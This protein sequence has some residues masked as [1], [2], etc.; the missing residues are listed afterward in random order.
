MS[1]IALITADIAT[2]EQHALLHSVGELQG[3]IPNLLRIVANSPAALRAF[4]D[5][6]SL[7]R[8]GSLDLPTRERIAIALAQ[9]NGSTYCLSVHAQLGSQA[10]L[11]GAEMESNRLGDSHDAK[12]AVAVR[13]AC[14]LIEHRGDLDDDELRAMRNAG[15]SDAEIVE[16]ISHTGLNFLSNLMSK[17][18]QVDIDF[19]LVTLN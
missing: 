6:H 13:F 4:L 2:R 5:L 9:K 3:Y 10:G 8:D 11:N 7:T 17:V 14:Q 18:S 12:A 16:V 15:Y 19:P 1:R